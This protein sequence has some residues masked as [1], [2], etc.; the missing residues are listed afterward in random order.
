MTFFQANYAQM[1]SA[2]QRIQ[3]ISK[4]IDSQLDTLR[5]RLQQLNWSGEDR[6]AYDQ[7]QAAWDA[8]VADMNTL[9]NEIGGGVGIARSNYMTTEMN[10]AK[11]W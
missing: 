9:L 4:A 5:Q 3:G 1:E 7:H 8:A 2:S 6:R 11:V 10:N